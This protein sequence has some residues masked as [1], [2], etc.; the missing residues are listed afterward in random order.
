[1]DK[2]I[3]T[4]L[5]DQKGK[6]PLL[7]FEKSVIGLFNDAMKNLDCTETQFGVIARLRAQVI[8][9]FKDL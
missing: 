6:I 9:G 1:M 4:S 5:K 2:Q 3:A 8:I 7:D